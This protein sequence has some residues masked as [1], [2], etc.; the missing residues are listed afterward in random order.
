MATLRRPIG[1]G[2]STAVGRTLPHSLTDAVDQHAT[3]IVSRRLREA[4]I[5]AIVDDDSIRGIVAL[6]FTTFSSETGPLE[7]RC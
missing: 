4:S 7:R 5:N 6:P 2:V 1:C 3:T